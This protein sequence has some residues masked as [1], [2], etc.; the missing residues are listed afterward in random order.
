MSHGYQHGPAGSVGKRCCFSVFFPDRGWI[1]YGRDVRESSRRIYIAQVWNTG[2]KDEWE[3][4]PPSTLCF[5]LLYHTLPMFICGLCWDFFIIF[6]KLVSDPMFI[7]EINSLNGSPS[8]VTLFSGCRRRKS[9]LRASVW[10]TWAP[11]VR[12][13][14]RPSARGLPAEESY[15]IRQMKSVWSQGAGDGWR[16]PPP[17]QLNVPPGDR[18][19]LQAE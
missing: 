1:L 17:D 15:W 6:V 7:S 12:L 10:I 2:L 11:S 13:S 3:R 5:R 8:T 19:Q 9:K 14:F 16:S 4:E 18:R